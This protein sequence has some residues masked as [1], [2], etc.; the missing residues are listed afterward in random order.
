[1]STPTQAE[2]RALVEEAKRRHAGIRAGV[3]VADSWC[4]GCGTGT[5]W[6]CDASRL[7]DALS[8]SL[9][10]EEGLRETC[11]RMDEPLQPIQSEV[12]CLWCQAWVYD[13]GHSKVAHD[14]RC[15]WVLTRTREALASTGGG[16]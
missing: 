16:E 4:I 3:V 2:A 7:A 14:P 1:M 12:H 9:A 13:D 10:R 11:A 8:A 5:P 6:P 15:P